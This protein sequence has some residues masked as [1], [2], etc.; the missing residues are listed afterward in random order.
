MKDDAEVVDLQIG[1]QVQIE[2]YVY[3]VV[4]HKRKV[5][6][7]KHA[8]AIGASATVELVDPMLYLARQ[9]SFD[10]MQ[11]MINKTPGLLRRNEKLAEDLG[12]PGSDA[13][14]GRG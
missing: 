3:V 12:L 1:S 10:A 11:A 14:S 4:G 13:E 2:G 6:R 5:G 8:P 9:E 7:D